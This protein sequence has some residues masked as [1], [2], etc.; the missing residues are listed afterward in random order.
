MRS[1]AN[2]SR[3]L[4]QFHSP[5]GLLELLEKDSELAGLIH[6]LLK[7]DRFH[8]ILFLV[9]RKSLAAQAGD[10]FNEMLMEQNMPLPQCCNFTQNGEVFPETKVK[11]ATVQAMVKQI[12]HGGEPPP[13]DQFDCIIIDEAH[14]GYTL[15]Q[16]MTE[17]EYAVRDSR[18]YQ[19][20]CRRVLDYFDTVKIGLTAT[21]A[22]HTTEIFGLTVFTCS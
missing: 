1:D 17:G 14:R 11:V 20:T 12:F 6:R 21:P 15:D 22:E 16:E 7:A 8:R 5:E 3:A 4:S 2:I 19:S 10:T 18:L 13:I 9:D